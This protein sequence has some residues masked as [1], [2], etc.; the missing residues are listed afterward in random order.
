MLSDAGFM[1]RDAIDQLFDARVQGPNI[2]RAKA[3]LGNR[4]IQTA[5][6]D[7]LDYLLHYINCR[8]GGC[9]SKLADMLAS[10]QPPMSN[11]DRE[12]LEG[13]CCGSQ[14]ATDKASMAVGDAFKK[15]AA[16]SG[17]S[18]TGKVY[19]GG[20]AAFPGDPKAW[21]SDRGD[22]KRVLTERGWGS[23]GSVN[24]A[25][26]EAPARRQSALKKVLKGNAKQALLG[27]LKA[28]GLSGDLLTGGK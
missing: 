4:I 22:V 24:Q 8:E 9:T 25:P 19:V 11:T 15:Q 12:F 10:R 2:Q 3:S 6:V 20:L 7:D 14:F 5:S 27:R 21:V 26:R 17:V 16:A 18:V 13:H 23:E 28:K 1:L